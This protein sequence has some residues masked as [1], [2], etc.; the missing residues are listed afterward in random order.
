MPL[1]HTHSHTLTHA[2]THARPRSQTQHI[3]R[4]TKEEKRGHK[5]THTQR[6]H[7]HDRRGIVSRGAHTHAYTTHIYKGEALL[8]V[9]E[10]LSTLELSAL[11]GQNKEALDCFADI[12]NQGRTYPLV[13]HVLIRSFSFSFISV[14]VFISNKLLLISSTLSRFLVVDME[15][16]RNEEQRVKRAMQN[17]ARLASLIHEYSTEK[18]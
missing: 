13:L 17:G 5:H 15:R 4:N 7:A 14:L 16:L 1:S 3:T 2:Y 11:K 18:V 6:T 10:G 8:A 12:L 9:A